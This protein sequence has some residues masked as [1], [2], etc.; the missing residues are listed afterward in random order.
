MVERLG[1]PIPAH[2]N[3]H[4]LRP[5]REAEGAAALLRELRPFWHTV[6][7]DTYQCAHLLR[8]PRRLKRHAAP[9]T[10]LH[11]PSSLNNC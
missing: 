6:Y 10:A 1:G 9:L 2:L 7:G 11:V 8:C 4:H 5:E 3:E